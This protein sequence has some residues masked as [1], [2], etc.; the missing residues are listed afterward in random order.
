MHLSAGSLLAHSAV[1]R[2]LTLRGVEPADPTAIPAIR[3]DARGAGLKPEVTST[4][5]KWGARARWADGRKVRLLLLSE[6]DAGR[7]AQLGTTASPLLALSDAIVTRSGNALGVVT[8]ELA[9]LAVSLFPAL[10]LPASVPGY[11]VTSGEDGIFQRVLFTG[12][13]RKV[14][15]VE[16]K[17][18]AD[19]SVV[20]LPSTAFDGLDDIFMEIDFVGDVCR[21]F[22][23]NTG[24]LVADFMNNG[25]PWQV[26]M[27]RF[28]KALADQGLLIRIAPDLAGGEMIQTVGTMT[29]KAG[30][31]MRGDKPLLIS[32]SFHPRY[33]VR[34]SLASAI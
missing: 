33:A 23:A 25:I 11:K 12:P 8:R 17:L 28:R 10:M 9:D 7:L 20:K 19:R 6:T 13:S 16:S 1:G 18:S 5:A 3:F 26:G 32:V 21:I 24:L 4:L 29:L 31:R 15:A 22:D 27:K 34:F 14:A 2:A 30:Q